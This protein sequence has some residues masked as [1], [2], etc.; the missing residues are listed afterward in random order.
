MVHRQITYFR[1]SNRAA[2]RQEE[3]KVIAQ[4]DL[5]F[6]E[7]LKEFTGPLKPRKSPSEIR[8]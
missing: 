1:Q 2:I 3:Q 5:L 6:Y 4:T 8:A 7:F